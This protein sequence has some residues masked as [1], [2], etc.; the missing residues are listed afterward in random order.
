MKRI[1]I[2]YNR[3]KEL[4]MNNGIDAKGLAETLGLSRAN[5]SSELNKLCEM[6]KVRKTIGR[7]VLFAPMDSDN[8]KHVEYITTLD[9]LLG[10]N[11]SL[12]TAG[13]QA[14]AAILYPPKGMHTLILGDTGVGKTMFA[15]IMHKYA[16][17]MEKM[18]KDSPF[19]TFNCADYSNNPQLLISQLFGVKK[20][21]YTGADSD[22]LGLIE[23]ANGG[24]L[25]LDEVH[26][27][28][29]EGQEMFFTFMDK[30]IFRRLG[31]TDLE[32]KSSVLIISA[33][34]E[35]PE[36]SLLKTFTRRIPMIIRIPGLNERGIEER[37]SL[38]TN[39]FREE[40]FR[41][42]REIMVSVNSMRAFLSYTCQNNVGQLRT[43]IQL[44][45][46]KAYA[47]LLSHKKDAVKINSP[48]L[49][50]FIREGLYRETEHRQFLNKL[51]G[52]N[53]HYC[54]FSKDEGKL[55]F[56]NEK[57]EENIYELI[58]F[59]VSE[60][61]DRGIDGQELEDIMEKDIESYFTQYFHGVNNR[62]N[63]ASLINVVDEIIIDVVEEIIKYSE[64][65][66]NRVFSQKV[67]LGMAIHIEASIDRIKKNKKII[68]P[69]LHKIRIEHN[70]EFNVALEC[71]KMIEKTM[72]INI[73]IDE[74]GFLTMFFILDSEPEK[75]DSDKVGVIVIAHGNSTAT[76]MV[77]V[78]NQLL[79]VKHAVGINA[80]L[81]MSPQSVL[82]R[83]KEYV[84]STNNKKGFV[85]LVDMG[86][87]ST[88]GD[89]IKKELNIPVRVVQ[90][91]STLHVIEA[92]RKALLGYDVDEI[93]RDIKNIERIDDE[94]DEKE[95]GPDDIKYTILT[96]CTTGEGSAIAIKKFLE[97]HLKFDNKTF[98]IVPINI[99]GKEDINQRIK[100]IGKEKEIICIICPFD[101]NTNIPQYGLDEVLNLKAI[102]KI[103]EVIDVQ[104][105]YLK[106]D[107]T[108]KHHLKNVDG[109]RIFEDIKKFIA[110]VEEELK[111]EINTDILIGIVLHIGC[112]IDRFKGQEAGVEYACKDEYIRDNH[113]LYSCIK[114]SMKFLNKKYNINITDDEICYIMNFFNNNTDSTN[115]VLA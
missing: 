93:Y 19:I 23:K 57:N 84:K 22:R 100:R 29:S 14:K 106:M 43:D 1:D 13:E 75:N 65:K 60:L 21:A 50:N 85:L 56:D 99:V 16:I 20:G 101:L 9:K 49:P 42:D 26:R 90:L 38:I 92:A 44:A 35:N 48:D 37:F 3:L 59:R 58:D 51:I 77:E 5:V 32:R 113:E 108:L 107:E 87:L 30:G 40:S 54:I 112:M 91:V 7:P 25:F 46:A 47:D 41:L 36:S 71:L 74:A 62:L 95:K 109:A 69:Q 68:N 81:D 61:K 67:Y 18:L 28:P 78:T 89:I 39:F 11:K 34:T 33:T 94:E 4:S 53:T 70:I 73:P 83:V 103:Q 10:D 27:L 97:K 88:F 76:S 82:I 12:K 72:D 52:I 104:N 55:I 6:G 102:K 86:S 105:T 8:G 114:S 17:E 2:V 98:E 79:G 111:V 15:G 96:A 110:L 24:I 31:E 66:L 115:S 64:L 45:C 80:P 63:K